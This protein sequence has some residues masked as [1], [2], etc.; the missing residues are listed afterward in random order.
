MQ[1]KT[2]RRCWNRLG[3][4]LAAWGIILG[5]GLWPTVQAQ[6][7]LP[8]APDKYLVDSANI[9]PPAKAAQINEELAAF[10]RDTSSQVVVAIYPSLPANAT[11]EDYANRLF[12]H[13]KIGQ[14]SK[15]NG[16]LLL[17]FTMDRKL[18]IEVGYGLEGA[19]PDA[20]ANRIIV[21][22]ITPAFRSGDYAGGVEAGVTAM[23]AAT[24]GEYRSAAPERSNTGGISVLPIAAFFLFWILVFTGL[25]W[26]ALR[27][28]RRR[29]GNGSFRWPQSTTNWK[30]SDS[31]SDWTSSS[32]SWSGS[33]SSS[34]S[35]SFSGGGGDSGGGGASGSW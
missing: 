28:A 16:V 11:I 13:W 34:S 5:F 12:H 27:G 23:M 33:D 26:L 10:D 2:H 9:I 29:R 20:L 24:R 6:D 1:P 4:G 7:N 15:D 8:P 25:F 3:Y 17:I 31:G 32:S 22:E 18:R 21:N 14:A 19:L 30:S 35:S